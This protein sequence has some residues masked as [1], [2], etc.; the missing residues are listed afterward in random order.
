MTG[1]ERRPRLRLVVAAVIRGD[2]G[3]I[4]VARRA[5]GQHLAGL[6]EFPG[7]AVEPG[8]TAEQALIRELDEELGTNA[9]VGSPITFAWHRDGERE[10]LL[11]FYRVRARCGR[12]VGR[13]G[14]E[15]RWVTPA[16]LVELPTPPA[17]SALVSL[18][19]RGQVDWDA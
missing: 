9:Q 1:A 8:E 10:I 12:P 6:W 19:A 17:D 11:L 4:L 3:R 7:G 5:E 13:Q 15:V 18:L 14:Q 2:D 16:E